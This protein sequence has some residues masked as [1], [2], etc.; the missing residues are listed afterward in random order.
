MVALF[1]RV[2]DDDGEAF[3]NQGVWPV[4]HLARRVAFG[5]YVRNL[6]ELERAFE[7]DGEVYAAP[8]VEKVSRAMELARKLLQLVRLREQML[9]LERKLRELL[10]VIARGR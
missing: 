7:R 8:E 3:V 5:V 9:N 10:R 4:L 1:A 6:L 2:D